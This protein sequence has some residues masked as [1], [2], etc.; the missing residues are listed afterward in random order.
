MNEKAV[1]PV[2]NTR[3]LCPLRSAYL[4]VCVFSSL[5]RVHLLVQAWHARLQ[6][7]HEAG[8]I[9]YIFRHHLPGS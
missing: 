9:Q 6:A 8:T 5:V 3:A 4:C 7:L 1:V 2:L